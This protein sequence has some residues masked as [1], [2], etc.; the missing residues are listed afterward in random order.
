VRQA[1]EIVEAGARF[2]WIGE[3]MAS[4]SLLSPS[5]YAE[6]ALPY[7][8]ELADEVRRLGA[9]SLLH[10]CGN[11]TPAL[12]EIAQSRVDGVDVDFLTDW[13][14]AVGTVGQ[15]MCVKGNVNPLL[16]LP[17]RSAD[18]AEACIA[19]C[20]DAQGAHGFILSTGCLVPRDS[21][22]EAFDVTAN[23]R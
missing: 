14:A 10:I 4:S 1:R 2:I 5:M 17:G 21:V 19:A 18:L 15:G 3:G 8:Q 20:R 7:E 13:R 11:T 6:F 9:L 22:R 12:A 16:F 23:T